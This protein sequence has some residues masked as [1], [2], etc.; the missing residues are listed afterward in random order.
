MNNTIDIMKFEQHEPHLVKVY[1]YYVLL[2]KERPGLKTNSEN[3]T[4]QSI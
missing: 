3:K 4:C 2:V 1:L